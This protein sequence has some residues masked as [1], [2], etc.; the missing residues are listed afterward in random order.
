MITNRFKKIVVSLLM[1]CDDIIGQRKDWIIR[2][3]IR[4][5][6]IGFKGMEIVVIR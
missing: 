6:Q 2:I 1:F 3:R 4:I 5:V